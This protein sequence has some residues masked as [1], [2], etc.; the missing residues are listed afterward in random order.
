MLYSSGDTVEHPADTV[1]LSVAFDCV[2]IM[3]IIICLGA[4]FNRDNTRSKRDQRTSLEAIHK[5]AF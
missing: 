5:T 4:F 2:N 3:I 1:P